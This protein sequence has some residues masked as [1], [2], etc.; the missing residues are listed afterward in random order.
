MA[1]T[2]PTLPRIAALTASRPLSTRE[3]A[4]L[5]DLTSGAYTAVVRDYNQDDSGEVVLGFTVIE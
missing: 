3:A 4:L 2:I 1:R 5:V